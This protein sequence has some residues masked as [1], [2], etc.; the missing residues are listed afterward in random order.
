M[1]EK[2]DHTLT[3]VEAALLLTVTRDAMGAAGSAGGSGGAAGGRL[4]V[5][6][7]RPRSA[8]AA[9][10]VALAADTVRERLRDAITE[11]GRLIHDPNEA[12]DGSVWGIVRSGVWDMMPALVRAQVEPSGTGRCEV[13]I[14]ATGREGLIKQSIGAKAADRLAQAATQG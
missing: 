5:R 12:H 10:D 1:A 13:L 14:R 2:S 4:G 8:V 6:L 9:V 11:H 3:E 7:T